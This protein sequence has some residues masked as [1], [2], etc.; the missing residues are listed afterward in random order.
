[1][2]H[3]SL[4]NFTRNV[5]RDLSCLCCICLV[6]QTNGLTFKSM[7]R[8]KVLESSALN[9]HIW[10]VCELVH[11]RFSNLTSSGWTNSLCST[12]RARHRCHIG[13]S[14]SRNFTNNDRKISHSVVWKITWSFVNLWNFDVFESVLPKKVPGAKNTQTDPSSIHS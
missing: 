12:S 7:D 1:M 2:S 13:F 4:I 6:E 3:L 11:T 10:A 9:A 5:S 14:G 8:V